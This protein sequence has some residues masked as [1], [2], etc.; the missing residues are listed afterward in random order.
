MSL[1]LYALPAL[2][3]LS[4]I[5]PDGTLDPGAYDDCGE[6]C[7][8]AIV[9]A[10]HGTP[11]SPASVRA[12]LGGIR[13]SGL[14]TGDDLVTALAFY[15]VKAAVKTVSPAE[16]QTALTEWNNLGFA[17]IVLGEWPSPGNCLHW[18][19]TT[20]VQGDWQFMNPWGGERQFLAWDAVPGL[21]RGQYVLVESGLHYNM[22][23]MKQ[24][25]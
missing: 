4:A 25:F 22:R 24:P 10:V 18:M 16:L 11:I 23:F 19:L 3:Q 13:S 8:A 7:V 6:T 2:N 21:F 17:T 5:L 1:G 20:G 9:A 12:N 14:T 15:N